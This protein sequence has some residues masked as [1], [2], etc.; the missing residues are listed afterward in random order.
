MASCLF[1]KPK[2]KVSVSRAAFIRPCRYDRMITEGQIRQLSFSDSIFCTFLYHQLPGKRITKFSSIKVMYLL[3]QKETNN[4]RNLHLLPCKLRK[5][6]QKPRTCGTNLQMR[7][8]DLALTLAFITEIVIEII[9]YQIHK[10]PHSTGHCS[11]LALS[12]FNFSCSR[13]WHTS[14]SLQNALYMRT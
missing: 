7:F 11:V 3:Q 14:H 13:E 12:A 9:I 8:R 10:R 5:T 2:N 1:L 6:S 4:K